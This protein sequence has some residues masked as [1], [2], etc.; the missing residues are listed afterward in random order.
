MGTDHSQLSA[1][2]PMFRLSTL[3]ILASFGTKHSATTSGIARLA[4]FRLTPPS[5]SSCFRHA[6]AIFPVLGMAAGVVDKCQS[7]YNTSKQFS[8]NVYTPA[9]TSYSSSP[10]CWL[11]LQAPYPWGVFEGFAALCCTEKVHTRKLSR[12]GR[13]KST[14][15][16][17]EPGYHVECVRARG[18]AVTY[19]L[20]TH[21]TTPSGHR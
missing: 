7:G 18:T 20:H 2:N 15:I 10:P 19:D 13:P 21:Q 9:N 16:I 17:L 4:L 12:S 5:S 6:Q 1:C 8:M 3:S 14:N 11:R